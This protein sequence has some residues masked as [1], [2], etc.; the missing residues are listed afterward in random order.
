LTDT[1]LGSEAYSDYAHW[2]PNFLLN[3]KE[4]KVRVRA[5]S[6]HRSNEHLTSVNPLLVGALVLK[7]EQHVIEERS[8]YVRRIPATIEV[9]GSIFAAH[10]T[11]SEVHRSAAS[12]LERRCDSKN[13]LE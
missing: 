13:A 1:R 6:A 3:L 9:F 8:L 4:F 7:V 10:E 11:A 5:T 12:A 2:R